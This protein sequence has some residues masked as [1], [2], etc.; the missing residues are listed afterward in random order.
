MC[1]PA[2]PVEHPDEHSSTVD[3][4]GCER[5][6]TRRSS[7]H[8]GAASANGDPRR[9]LALPAGAYDAEVGQRGS[10]YSEANT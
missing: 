8:N 10:S 9:S 5:C 7:D 2:V 4:D 3:E 1:D 6:R